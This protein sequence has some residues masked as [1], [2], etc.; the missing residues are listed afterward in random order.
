MLSL[1]DYVFATEAG[2]DAKYEVAAEV[3]RVEAFALLMEVVVF[4]RFPDV[5]IS[6]EVKA[7][8]LSMEEGNGALLKG[9]KKELC[10]T[11]YVQP[12]EEN[13]SAK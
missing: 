9:V 13:E 8:A 3:R 5:T 4:V 6:S 10:A 11:T 7:N 12:M 1:V 2:N